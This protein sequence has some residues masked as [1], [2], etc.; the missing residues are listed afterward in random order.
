MFFSFQKL[1][2]HVNDTAQLHDSFNNDG[3]QLIGA[4]LGSDPALIKEISTVGTEYHDA[5]GSVDAL[6]A[7]LDDVMAEVA[8]FETEHDKIDK[9]LKVLEERTEEINAKA[10]GSEPEEI[11]KQLEEVKVR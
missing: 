3:Q 6:Q 1:K 8:K 10:V 5:T 4:G 11:N 9:D 7:Q 2:E